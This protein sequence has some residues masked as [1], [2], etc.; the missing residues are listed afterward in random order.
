MLDILKS[1]FGFSW[2]MSLFGMRQMMQPQNSAAAL[3]AVARA[4]RESLN[5]PLPRIHDTGVVNGPG[6]NGHSRATAQP[7]VRTPV[8][9]GRLDTAG[10]VVLSGLMIAGRIVFW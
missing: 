7:S 8:D 3:D 1:A 2:A 4:A 9:S 6:T 5:E 10:F